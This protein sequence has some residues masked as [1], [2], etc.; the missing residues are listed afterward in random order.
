MYKKKTRAVSVLLAATLAFSSFAS[1]LSG[2]AAET[3]A[4]TEAPET[5]A[6]LTEAAAT[7]A[8][9][10][11]ASATESPA[12]EAPVT[13]VPATEAPVPEASVTETQVPQTEPVEPVTEETEPATE[14]TEPV[15]EGT[16]PM[17]EPVT[18]TEDLKGAAFYSGFWIGIGYD[19]GDGIL[20]D[21]WKEHPVSEGCQLSL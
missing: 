10:T 14:A 15:T 1:P 7:E 19:A 17:T 21:T 20:T 13:E 3:Q 12:T 18:E 2:V 16:E 11:E 4:V 5:V 8:T 6:Q 9:P